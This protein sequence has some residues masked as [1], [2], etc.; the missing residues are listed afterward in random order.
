MSEDHGGPLA[1]P[2]MRLDPLIFWDFGAAKIQ[3]PSGFLL[4]A[5]D[6]TYLY[7]IDESIALSWRRLHRF[8]RK[9]GFPSRAWLSIQVQMAL[10]QGTDQKTIVDGRGPICSDGPP[11]LR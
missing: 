1:S 10:K 4:M 7:Q 2:E 6:E 8:R 5:T 9:I 3:E 11:I